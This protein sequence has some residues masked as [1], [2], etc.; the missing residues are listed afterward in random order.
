[1][2]NSQIDEINVSIS[3]YLKIREH[4]KKELIDKLLKKN[5]NL[6]DIL[7][8]IEDY[9]K[10]NLQSD[11]RYAEDLIRVK[12]NAGKGP[13][14]IESFLKSQQI[15]SELIKEGLSE[16]SQSDWVELAIKSLRKKFKN[17][18]RVEDAEKLKSFL[19]YRGFPYNIIELA[20]KGYD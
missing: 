1:M 12:F 19:S 14:F 9:S 5:Y 3:R 8:R 6:E 7:S 13:K 20:I 10:R 16:Y 2:S 15:P 4:S 18:E 17:N 11:Q